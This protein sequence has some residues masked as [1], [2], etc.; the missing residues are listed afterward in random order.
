M[1]AADAVVCASSLP[2]PFGRVIIESMAVGT[3]VVATDAG[4]ATDIISDGEN[5]ILVPVKDSEALA[6]AIVRL[7]QDSDLTQKL[8]SAAMQTVADRYTVR[9]H[10]DQVCGIYRSVLEL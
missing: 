4:G 10:V 9:R 6:H 2:E 1:K 3:P 5:G 8:R 7:S